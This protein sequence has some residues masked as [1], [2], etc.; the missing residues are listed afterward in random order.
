[1][2]ETRIFR[3]RIEASEGDGAHVTVPFA[4]KAATGR[5]VLRYTFRQRSAALRGGGS[6]LSR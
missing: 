3:A 6:P 5:G 2:T 4:V 1:V